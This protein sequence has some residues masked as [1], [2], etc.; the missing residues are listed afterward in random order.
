M[1]TYMTAAVLLA[2]A[3]VSPAQQTYT[4]DPGHS[5]AQFSVRHMMVATVR[6]E[7]GKMSGTIVYDPKNLAASKVEAAIDVSTISTRHAKRDAHLKSPDFLDV[8][9]YPNITFQS[10]QVSQVNG[11]LQIRGDLTMHGV[12]REVTLAVEGPSPEIKDPLGMH[13]FGASATT[14][15]NRRDFGL[16]YSAVIE[17]GAAVVGDEVTI[18]LDIEAIRK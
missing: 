13:R 17:T 3:T 18:T 15:I 10:K 7:F 5:S 6:G 12:T 9:K 4:I 11:Q 14:R 1:K 8:A 16:N 2:A